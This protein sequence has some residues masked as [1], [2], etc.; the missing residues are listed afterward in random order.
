M[1]KL[2]AHYAKNKD[3]EL[4]SISID[5]NKEKWE[6][7]LAEDK[8]KWKQFICLDA[9]ESQLCKNYDINGIPRFLFFDKDGKVISLE[10]PRPSEEGIIEYIDK[11]LVD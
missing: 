5:E 6:K 1:E 3:I 7:K 9:F 8:P 10:A 11:H 2:A 4:I